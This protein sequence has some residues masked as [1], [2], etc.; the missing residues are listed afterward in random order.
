MDDSELDFVDLC[1]KLLKRVRKKA[2]DPG[3]QSREAE[4][5]SS[6]HP[7]RGTKR[8][9][10]KQDGDP[11][12][13]SAA[14]QPVEAGGS[15]CNSGDAAQPSA[16]GNLRAK[17]K[18]L[19]RMQAFKRASPQRMKHGIGAT[20]W[21]DCAP[22]AHQQKAD[23]PSS[24][25][26]GPHP[27]NPAAESDEAVALR[28]QQ[29]LDRE[30]AEAQVVDLEDGGLFFCQICHRDLSHMSSEGRTQHLNRCL[31]QN[32][33]S[34]PSLPPHSAVPDCP[35]CGK[36]FKTQ[37]SRSGHLKRCSADMG[38]SPAVL[39][40]ALQRQTEESRSSTTAN[41]RMQPGGSK[42]KA[43]AKPELPARK[44][45]KKKA[46]PLDEETMVALALSSSLLERQKE[47]QAPSGPPHSCMT[48][49]LPWKP[50]AARRRVKN[51]RVGAPRPPPLLLVQDAETALAR[52][53][54]RVSAL[55][56]RRRAP[57][58]PTPTRRPSRLP[59]WTGAA[60]L[61]RKST[62]QDGGAACL[63]D[64]YAAELRTLFAPLESAKTDAVLSSTSDKPETSVPPSCSPAASAPATRELH[65]GSQA[66]QV[67]IELA[68]DGMTL[69]QSGHSEKAKHLSGF[70]QEEELAGRAEP[71]QDTSSS[72]S[73]SSSR[74][75]ARGSDGPDADGDGGLHES[76]ALSR[77]SSDLSSMVN[78]PQLSD[79]QLQ[80][81][82]GEVFF[83][84]SFMVYA[85]CPLLAEM[86]HESGFGVQEE[87][88]PAARRVLLSDV[89]GQ[90]VSALLQYLYTAR[91]SGAAA[92][93]PH[94]LELASRFD[95]QEL[96]QLLL[97][98][99][100]PENTASDEPDPSREENVGN[101]TDQA[102][103]EL[104]RSMW[105]E[106]DEGGDTGDS[107]GA[108]RL[109]EGRR[110]D[111]VTAGDGEIREERVNEEEL[112]E[113][114][115]FAATQRQREERQSSV[116]EEEDAEQGGDAAGT[117]LQ[118]DPGSEP[119]SDRSYSRL[120]SQS[121][122][123]YDDVSKSATPPQSKRLPA[124]RDAASKHSGRNLLQSSASVVDELPPN[125]PTPGPSPGRAARRPDGGDRRGD[126]AATTESQSPRR[127][128]RPHSPTEKAEPDLIVLS[129]SSEETDANCRLPPQS[130]TG[131]RSSHNPS[132]KDSVGSFEL[133]PD[134]AGCSP[135]LSWL[136]PSTPLQAG[137]D[138]RTSS[139]QTDSSM[140]KKLFPREASPP[141]A[142]PPQSKGQASIS[143]LTRSAGAGDAASGE[144]GP[145]PSR[146]RL[147]GSSSDLR[148]SPI[149]CRN[150]SEKT[151]VFAARLSFRDPSQ[152]RTPLQLRFPPCSST[153]LHP[154]LPQAPVPPA[155]WPL[156]AGPE[157]QDVSGR[158]KERTSLES[159]EAAE[160]GSFHLSPLS[161]PS[162]P[163]SSSS[164]AKSA[165]SSVRRALQRTGGR[166]EPEETKGDGCVADVRESSFHQSFMDEP[167][168][169]FNDSWGPD[170]HA[171]ASP[172]GFSLRLRESGESS[173]PERPG[174]SSASKPAS[175][176][177]DQNPAA[178]PGS[179]V[180]PEIDNGL[181]DS[182]IWDSWEGDEEEEEEK[183]LPLSQR[184]NL[185]AL[186]KTPTPLKQ[187]RR[188]SVVPITPMPHY[189]DMDTPDLKSKLSS[190]GV[191]PLP[192][193]QM[194]LKL[195][196]IHQYTHQLAS[197]DSEEEEPPRAKPPLSGAVSCAQTGRFK[198]P[199]APA[200]TSP[201]KANQEE[202]GELLS[203]SQGSN[204]SSTAASEESERSNPELV[205]SSD[206]DSESEGGISSS[207]AASRLQDRLQA[208]RAFILSDSSLCSRILQY[209]P[210][211]LSQLQQQLKAAGI[212]LGAA[213]LVDYLDSQCIT[214][215]T[216]KPGHPAASR[217]RGKTAG[218]GARGGSRKNGAL[219]L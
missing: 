191:R 107:D 216:A 125:L 173:P 196:E 26:S 86:V 176:S 18:V 212:R 20:N 204:T 145:Q 132:P 219:K 12:S 160:S 189:S 130:Y 144:P 120:F 122:G 56:L 210:L 123:V 8:E 76:V 103:M 60:P 68:E 170:A 150:A 178:G 179:P 128:C 49:V 10:N 46:G 211:V 5:R 4:Q 206:G 40:Q 146:N 23:K 63:S 24:P 92:L 93:R 127:T 205:L 57:S 22:T 166:S 194:V 112:E 126:A 138:T 54:E 2:A 62:L 143:P 197:S 187:R 34:D 80:V 149:K 192:K 169:A 155:A 17:D 96:Q 31:D 32:E 58:P 101:Q 151:E 75:A 165:E 175:D 3:K 137:R 99:S 141:P 119:S 164:H 21:D 45:K 167:P 133:S 182:K 201:V 50:D 193:R 65:A 218:R 154:E 184:L 29:Q 209:Q 9:T 147:S 113:I 7:S 95:L 168:I 72:S 43:P 89:P 48:S 15:G 36:K 13:R 174:S 27:V 177:S 199:R 87:G 94:M 82:S 71:P 37:K 195:K 171:E 213:K 81:D 185:D 214:F 1:S 6:G 70:L 140:C 102:F 111:E 207:Q 35:I 217:R 19:L 131:I 109:E 200:T 85:R 106:E 172:A 118:P 74:Q 69:T 67:L 116:E 136:I 186:L 135:E 198:E 14:S 28:L 11:G 208:V 134:P 163:P 41:T 91:C 61:W 159:L 152:H 157:K 39:L 53:Q 115:E 181:L 142:S 55:L 121:W 38:V 183:D 114:Y 139:V 156:H 98:D 25:R 77:L 203:A 66:L 42:R 110:E 83:A 180:T 44:K 158:M 148:V 162:D 104:I 30:A 153:P 33:Q 64:F 78:N 16:G 129:D 161:S 51:K 84:H 124:P 100:Q 59:G 215:T 108:G 90:A 202:D 97:C 105:H 52:L 47:Q 79:V 117:D 190:F 88:V 188:R 73:S